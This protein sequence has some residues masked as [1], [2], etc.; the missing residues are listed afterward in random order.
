MRGLTDLAAMLRT[1]Q[2]ELLPREYVFASLPG[3]KLADI[4]ALAPIGS[5]QEAEGLSEILAKE[6]A[7][8]H[9]IAFA[10][11][12]RCITLH[13]HS[14]LAAVGLTAAIATRLADEGISA[15][16]VSGFFHD[17]IFVPAEDADRGFE[18]L[19]SLQH[20]ALLA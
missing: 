11:T 4:A 19:R 2:P 18:A 16:L 17:H 8:A 15:N 3:A 7:V 13:L 14:D 6:V 1:L 5:F 10:L 9:E 12:L 20:S